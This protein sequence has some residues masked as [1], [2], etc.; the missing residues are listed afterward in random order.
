MKLICFA[1]RVNLM[2]YCLAINKA[3]NP[4]VNYQ[5]YM[6]FDLMLKV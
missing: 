2:R 5:G 4:Y 6:A 3:K 1:N